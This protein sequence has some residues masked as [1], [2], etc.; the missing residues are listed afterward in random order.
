[1]QRQVYWFLAAALAAIGATSLYLIHANRQLFARLAALSDE[2]RGLAQ[3]LIT[4]RENTLR[5]ISRELHDEFGQVL[6]AIGSMLKRAAR[7]TDEG[8]LLRA[9][10]RE[11]GEVAQTALD[12]VRGLSQTLHPSILEELGLASTVDWYLTTVERQL[13]LRVTYE[14]PAGPMPVDPG[15]AIHVYRVLQEALSNVARHA[16]TTDAIVRLACRDGVLHLEVEDHGSGLRPGA[17]PRGLGLVAMRER[18]ELVGGRVT[19]SRPAAGGTLVSL[20]VPL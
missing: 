11:V 14:R 16:G 19:I 20:V 12:S 1:V 2:R 7:H 17:G 9:D 18:A 10:L 13:G 5:E 6:T 8:S 3:A 4:T 15:V